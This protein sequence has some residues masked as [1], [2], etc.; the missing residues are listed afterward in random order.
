MPKTLTASQSTARDLTA[1]VVA[2]ILLLKLD[3]G[4]LYIGERGQTSFDP[5]PNLTI[6]PWLVGVP[7]GD[8]RANIAPED[9]G[10]SGEIAVAEIAIDPTVNHS[11]AN[12]VQSETVNGRIAEAYEVYKPATGSVTF[13]DWIRTGFFTIDRPTT[14]NSRGT[15]SIS[16]IDRV[17]QIAARLSGRIATTDLVSTVPDRSVG[18]VLPQIFGLIEDSPGVLLTGGARSTLASEIGPYTG[19][20]ELVDASD[21]A[22]SGL[23]LIG[24]EGIQYSAKSGNTIGTAAT[25]VVRGWV[26]IPQRHPEGA[27]VLRRIPTADKYRWL[28]A[29]QAGA[30]ASDVKINGIVQ[31]GSNFAVSTQT[32]GGKSALVVDVDALPDLFTDAGRVRALVLHEARDGR[33]ISDATNATPVVITCPNGHN[34]LGGQAIFQEGIE[35]NTA[36][37]GRLKVKAASPAPTA[38]TYA[39]TDMDDVEIVGSGAY[40]QGGTAFLQTVQWAEGNAN[41]AVDWENVIDMS[42]ERLTSFAELDPN[43]TVAVQIETPLLDAF[44][45]NPDH[46][47]LGRL[48]GVRVFAEWRAIIGPTDGVWPSPGGGDEPFFQVNW[49]DGSPQNATQVLQEPEDPEEDLDLFLTGDDTTDSTNMFGLSSGTLTSER[50][51]LLEHSAITAIS[52]TTNP[53]DINVDDSATDVTVESWEDLDLSPGDLV[54]PPLQP[55]SP[56]SIEVTAGPAGND[57]T[58]FDPSWDLATW[59]IAVTDDGTLPT[60]LNVSSVVARVTFTGRGVVNNGNI[61]ITLDVNGSIESAS[62]SAGNGNLAVVVVERSGTFDKTDILATTLKIGSPNTTILAATPCQDSLDKMEFDVEKIEVFVMETPVFTGADTQLTGRESRLSRSTQDVTRQVLDN[63]GWAWFQETNGTKPQVRIAY[64]NQTNAMKLRVY[65][66]G[67][68]VDV[69]DQDVDLITEDEAELTADI[70]GYGGASNTAQATIEE[71]ITG[72]RFMALTTNDYDQ[73]G[74]VAALADL[75]I[76]PWKLARHINT[77]DSFRDL[78]ASAV[79]DSGIRYAVEAGR[80]V[81]FPRIGNA[82]GD[83]IRT[84]ARS[85]MPPPA[86]DVISGHVDLVANRVNVFHTQRF[87]SDAAEPFAGNEVAND[88]LSQVLGLGVRTTDIFS[89]WLRDAPQAAELATR[90]VT[91]FRHIRD[92]LPVPTYIGRTFDLEIGDV[93]T[94]DDDLIDMNSATGRII[95]GSRPGDTVHRLLVALADDAQTVEGSGDNRIDVGLRPPRMEIFIGGTLVAVLVFSGLWIAGELTEKTNTVGVGQSGPVVFDGGSSEWRFGVHTVG[96]GPN[97]VAID[98]SGN[99]RLEFSYQLQEQAQY[100]VADVAATHFEADGTT[101][102]WSPDLLRRFARI[103][104]STTRFIVRHLREDAF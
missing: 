65:R 9:L 14:N 26:T 59:D 20:I 50:S 103:D 74:L 3:S 40:T 78:L 100:P 92:S 2:R 87:V 43:D 4:W 70:T 61:K 12:I 85:I 39:I 99:L 52:G 27:V 30:S 53:Q 16:M 32:I 34:F 75:T 66:L 67:F 69:I 1:H 44:Q 93:V 94:L 28:L 82:A 51:L 31:D 47:Y 15:V 46:P 21:F 58:F 49:N 89:P 23:L 84:V 102:D 45:N 36:A 97:I 8:R 11:I 7:A 29:D 13:D 33:E 71:I 64:P 68:E 98:A 104:S 77:N 10:G 79:R 101:L 17:Q 76:S 56:T 22:G 6:L 81:F 19:T 83:S 90:I 37:N 35:G 72:D 60:D 95:A 18:K 41:N 5:D 96:I 55:T 80:T 42:S 54:D 48:V 63:G 57:V 73:T 91:D 24:N 88:Q 86:P 62:A 25:P 38:T